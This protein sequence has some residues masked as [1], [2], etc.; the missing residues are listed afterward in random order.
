MILYCGPYDLSAFDQIINQKTTVENENQ[1]IDTVLKLFVQQIG[2]AYLGESNWQN[3]PNIGYTDI[4]SY[5]TMAFPKTYITDGNSISFMEH[6]IR[7]EK[8]L[9]E[10]GVETATY[11]PSEHYEGNFVHEYQFDFESYGIQAVE[12][13]TRTLQFL[14]TLFDSPSN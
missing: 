2:W 1:L 9:I 7:L 8:K 11:F 3:S 13:L 14:E 5:L 4:M 10:L 6:G 12:N